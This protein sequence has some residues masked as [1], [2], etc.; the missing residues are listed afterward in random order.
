M[1]AFSIGAHADERSAT[2]AN[3]ESVFAAAD[4]GDTIRLATGDY[5]T[6]RGGAKSGSVTL[7][8]AA[9]ADVT[10]APSLSGASHITFDGLTVAGAYLTGSHDITFRNSRFTDMSQVDANVANAGILFDHDTFDGINQCS[11]CYE[12]RLTVRG[13]GDGKPSG[14]VVTNSHFGG[15]GNPT[16]SRSRATPTG[17]RSVRETSSP[18][19]SR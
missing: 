2:P 18:D 8:P 6:F 11:D 13:F 16:A 7:A 17:Y 12:G 14:V 4:A 1:F 5:G 10:I 19:C 3:L 15:G 9:G